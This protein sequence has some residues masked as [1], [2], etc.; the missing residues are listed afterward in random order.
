MYNSLVE[1]CFRDCVDSFRRKDLD[2][3]EEKV[4]G[5]VGVGPGWEME[6]LGPRVQGGGLQAATP[7]LRVL[8]PLEPNPAPPTPPLCSAYKSAVRSS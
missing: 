8:A 5:W 6:S 1:K 2:S 3:T 7:S 4:G